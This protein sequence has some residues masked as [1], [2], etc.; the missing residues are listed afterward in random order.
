MVPEN[1]QH[2]ML[3]LHTDRCER[4]AQFKIYTTWSMLL[5][6]LVNVQYKGEN[7]EWNKSGRTFYFVHFWVIS[8]WVYRKMKGQVLVYLTGPV[9]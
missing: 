7:K 8:L 1:I 5:R 3:L 4:V 9:Q 6:V 2:W